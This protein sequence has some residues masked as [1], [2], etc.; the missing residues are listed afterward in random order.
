MGKEAN[1]TVSAHNP[2]TLFVHD[3]P[4][5]QQWTQTLRP[6][7]WATKNSPATSASYLEIPC[8][9][10]L[11]QDD[12]AV[13]LFVRELMVEK[14]RSHGAVIGTAKVKTGHT[15]WFVV[16]DEVAAFIKKQIEYISN[17]LF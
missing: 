2:Y 11:C 6:H 12:R 5:G 9:Y 14:A 10:L 4:N 17:R 8:S 15:P 1:R 16:P 3:V 7:A 13:P